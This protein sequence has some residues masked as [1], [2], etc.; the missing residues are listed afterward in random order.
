MK[1]SNAS[2]KN[3][4][5]EFA[6]RSP[7]QV[8]DEI[9]NNKWDAFIDFLLFKW[10]KKGIIGAHDSSLRLSYPFRPITELVIILSWTHTKIIIIA[11]YPQESHKSYQNTIKSAEKNF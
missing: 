2:T 6:L 5:F 10:N 7:H 9:Q 4:Y 8:N 3:N 1:R 11:Q